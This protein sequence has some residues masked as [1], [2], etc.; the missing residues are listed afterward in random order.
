LAAT[1]LHRSDQQFNDFGYQETLEISRPGRKAMHRSASQVWRA[2]RQD[3]LIY[4]FPVRFTEY[5]LE[6]EVSGGN[7]SFEKE[8]DKCGA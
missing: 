3:Q 1:R 7:T 8:K 2:S 6:L 4:C 5:I